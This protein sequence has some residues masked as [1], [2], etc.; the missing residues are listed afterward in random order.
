MDARDDDGVGPVLAR[1]HLAQAIAHAIC[2]ENPEA[3]VLVRAG[4]LRVSC[5]SPCRVSRAAIEHRFGRSVR[6]PADLERAMPSFRGRLGL[7]EEHAEWW[8]DD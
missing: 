5:P 4:Y 3:K 7:S 1:G 6:L 2:D 8:L